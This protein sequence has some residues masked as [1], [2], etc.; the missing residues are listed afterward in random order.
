MYKNCLGSTGLKEMKG[1]WRAT[2]AWHQESPGKAYWGWSLSVSWKSRTEGIIHRIWGLA[3]GRESMRSYWWKCHLVAAE[4]ASVLEMLVLENDHERQQHMWSGVNQSL[5]CYRGQRR[6][7]DPS[8]LEEPRYWNKKLW[9]WSF[10]RDPKMLEMPEPW[11]TC[12]GKLLTGSG[13]SP[14]E[15]I[16]LQSTKLKGVGHQTWKHRVW[17]LSSWFSFLFSI[18]SLCCFGMVMYILWY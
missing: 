1:S 13:M 15:G 14:R 5:E 17:N 2:E 12:P 7:S 9:S 4:D 8:S 16:V 10:I 6:R 18:S 3:Q 11:D